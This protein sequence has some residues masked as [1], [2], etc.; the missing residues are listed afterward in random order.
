M[1][2]KVLLYFL[3]LGDQINSIENIISIKADS[4]NVSSWLKEHLKLQT[5]VH[6][7]LYNTHTKE[8][9]DSERV[10]LT[11]PAHVD[12]ATEEELSFLINP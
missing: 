3:F 4:V 5:S 8:G 1:V 9:T 11:K 12:T 10:V 6:S 7:K 2:I